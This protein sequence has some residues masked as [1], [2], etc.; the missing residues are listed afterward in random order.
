MDHQYIIINKCL[1][2][3][4]QSDMATMNKL[5]VELQLIQMKRILLNHNVPHE[6]KYASCGEE[7]FE[8]LF[9]DM[10]RICEGSCTEVAIIDLMGRIGT[11]LTRLGAAQRI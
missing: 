2:L 5:R 10:R 11:M 3:L 4:K 8:G 1:Q 9:S 7:V 6:L